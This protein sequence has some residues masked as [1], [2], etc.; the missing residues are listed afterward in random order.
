MP[1]IILSTLAKR[2]IFEIWEFIA[3]DN[4]DAADRLREDA[5]RTF[6]RIVAMPEIGAFRKFKN[7]VLTGLR[8]CPIP[9]FHRYL[10]F[11][12]LAKSGVEIVRVLHGARDIAVIF[13]E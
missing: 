11:Y 10:I 13:D 4:I 9:N 12:R 2:D 1:K 5:F 3:S 6:E 7:P 8:L